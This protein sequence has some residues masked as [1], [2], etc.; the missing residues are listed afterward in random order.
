MRMGARHASPHSQK[1]IPSP[2]GVQTP[3]RSENER[4]LE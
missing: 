2:N 1:N 3:L 4:E